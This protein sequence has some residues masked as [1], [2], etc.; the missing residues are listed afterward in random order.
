MYPGEE[1]LVGKNPI[2]EKFMISWKYIYPC[3]RQPYA[4]PKGCDMRSTTKCRHFVMRTQ[5]QDFQRPLRPPFLNGAHQLDKEIWV[6]SALSASDLKSSWRVIELF[7]AT[8][9]KKCSFYFIFLSP[10]KNLKKEQEQ[11]KYVFTTIR[12]KSPSNALFAGSLRCL[13]ALLNLCLDSGICDIFHE[14]HSKIVLMETGLTSYQDNSIYLLW[15]R[16]LFWSL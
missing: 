3:S 4:T 10:E 13:V 16:R 11:T 15:R 1:F 7:K 12:N 14:M 9:E 5:S 8:V 6:M 2:R